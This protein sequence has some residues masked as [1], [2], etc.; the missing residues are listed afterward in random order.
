MP[1]TKPLF[2]SVAK[3]YDTLNTLFSIGI[4]RLWR[5]RLV[6][7]IGSANLV[8]DIATGTAEVAIEASNRLNKAWVIGIDPSEK[9][10]RLGRRKIESLRTSG[11]VTLIQGVAENLPFKD[12]T[13][14]GVTIAFGIRNT[15]D[16]LK[17]LREMKRVLRPGGKVG[18]L[19]FA[20][21]KN[22]FFGPVYMFYL[23]N[24]LPL[25]GSLF[26]TKREYEYLGD[27]I[28][29]FPQRESFVRLMEETGFNVEKTIELT[30]G[31]VII[32]I[33]TK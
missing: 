15:I 4:D 23:R 9:M 10:L 26:G 19:E 33:G 25:V 12:D 31:T 5:R 6:R 3:N 20:V 14:D 13:F 27:S 16:P 22:R 2:N 32:Y 30:V 8:L 18:V 1:E 7:E 17:S 21:P 29:E 24:V 28:S 11:K